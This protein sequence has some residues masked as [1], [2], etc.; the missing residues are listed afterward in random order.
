MVSLVI[1]VWWLICLELEVK[2]PVCL[3][4]CEKVV[5]KVIEMGKMPYDVSFLERKGKGGE[6]LVC[7]GNGRAG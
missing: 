6:L 5:S 4:A 3:R 7:C 1:N 2:V